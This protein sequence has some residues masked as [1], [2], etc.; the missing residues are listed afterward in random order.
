MPYMSAHMPIYSNHIVDISLY[1]YIYREREREIHKELCTLC[2]TKSL[3]PGERITNV[4]LCV[5]QVHID[6]N[7]S[8]SNI[9]KRSLFK[10]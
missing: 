2:L 3:L 10:R 7:I 6:L 5:A 9:L 8:I 4:F 1:I